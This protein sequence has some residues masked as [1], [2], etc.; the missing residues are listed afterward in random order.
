M[1]VHL[2]MQEHEQQQPQCICQLL[3]SSNT[4]ALL[5][6]AVHSFVVCFHQEGL[7]SLQIATALPMSPGAL[8]ALIP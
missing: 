8:S 4:D 7:F 6:Y 5:C 2:Q 1:V 3:L